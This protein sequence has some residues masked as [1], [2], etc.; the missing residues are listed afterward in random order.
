M[1][2]GLAIY[3]HV[4]QNEQDKARTEVNTW[5]QKIGFKKEK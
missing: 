1:L 4:A 3:G 5:L 2:D